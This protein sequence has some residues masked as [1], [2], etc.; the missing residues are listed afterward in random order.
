MIVGT[1]DVWPFFACVAFLMALAASPAL[2]FADAPPNPKGERVS[3]LDGLRGFLALSV[4]FCHGMVYHGVISR[5]IWE[6]PPSNFYTV[7]GQAG[8]AIFFMITGYL[9]W[10]MMIKDGGKPR[11]LKLYIGRVFRIG[12][13]YLFAV[14]VLFLIVFSITGWTLHE[15]GWEVTKEI[16]QWMMLGFFGYGRS[17]NSFQ[18]TGWIL[19]GVTWTLKYEWLFY[20]SLLF[21]S[22]AA[23]SK[24]QCFIFPLVTLIFLLTCMISVTLTQT[25]SNRCACVALF[26][27]GMLSA[28]IQAR[29]MNLSIPNW[30]S[31]VLVISFI[32]SVFIFSDTAY[33]WF[34]IIL[35]GLAFFLIVSGSNVFGLLSNRAARRLGNVSY[36]I[37]LLQGLVLLSFFSLGP[38]RRFALASPEQGWEAL[39]VCSVLL[40]LVAT[41]THFLI[42]QP[43]I[44][45]GQRLDAAI[46]ARTG[47]NA[48]PSMAPLAP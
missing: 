15:P 5:N 44:K 32:S 29:A 4:F 3:T 45:I 37:Y 48:T 40:V 27:V 12:P 8:V 36:G 41:M 17:I 26:S 19:A 24:F 23:R 34:P 42:E 18:H 21:T 7:L 16:S 2:K 31:S 47:K 22:F 1:Y 6:I 39:S 14:F 46:R 10:S 20:F 33:A 13:L 11:W 9:F 35:M 38:V 30:L 25:Q 28:A 43:G